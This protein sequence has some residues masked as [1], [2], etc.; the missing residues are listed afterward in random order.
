MS[1]RPAISVVMPVKNCGE[2]LKPAVDSILGQSFEDFEL[3]LIDD[4]SYDG[5]IEILP[6]DP[7]LQIIRHQGSGIVESLNLGLVK[8]R[9]EFV[10]RM[11]GDD[12]SFPDRFKKQI[13]FARNNPDI[14]IVSGMVEMFSDEGEI[15]EGNQAYQNWLNSMQTHDDV[16]RELFVESPLV[17]PSV[18]MRRSIFKQIG[19]YRDLSWP[20]DYDLWLRAWQSGI[21]F[22]KIPQLVL[23]WREH[24]Q[25]LTRTDKRYAVKEFIK[26]KAWMLAETLLKDRPAIICGTGKLAVKLCDVLMALGVDVR[27]FV[28]V[29]PEKIGRTRRDLPVLSFEDML[30]SRENAL[31]LGALGARGAGEKLREIF[32][33]SQLQEGQ[34]FILAG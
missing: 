20:E 8:A 30:S 22:A 1:D 29:A 16:T 26:A 19:L 7:R 31:L 5:S 9:G 21:R 18:L 17:H 34:D 24:E 12:V 4:H 3:L 28:D 25:R 13:E 33:A 23:M 6:E 11:D 15:Q 2:W 10:A 14:D 32:I 27:A